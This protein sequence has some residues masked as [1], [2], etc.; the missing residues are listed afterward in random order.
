MRII[1]KIGMAALACSM[2]I[3]MSMTAYAA[4]DT[5]YISS[6]DIYQ[7]AGYD[8]DSSIYKLTSKNSTIT[9]E[10]SFTYF[11]NWKTLPKTAIASNSRKMYVYLYEDDASP[12]L[13]DLVK[14]YEVSF[15]GRDVSDVKLYKQNATGN[16]DSSGDP[17]G[18]FYIKYNL[19]R[20]SGD[21][22]PVLMPKK[23]FEYR[24]KVN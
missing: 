3:G 10:N 19:K 23:Y 22:D 21:A 8:C 5:G 24:I 6:S 16:I 1:K 15:K 4:T 20:V 9:A 13:D 11:R 7:S 17:T 2:T 12:N 18:E 14:T